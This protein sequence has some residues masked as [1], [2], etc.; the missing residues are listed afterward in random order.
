[1]PAL[2][3]SEFVY[4]SPMSSKKVWYDKFRESYTL[5]TRYILTY[6]YWKGRPSRET[7]RTFEKETLARFI[8]E[9]NNIEKEGL[10]LGE[11]RELITL[12]LDSD[13]SLGKRILG[14]QGLQ[15]EQ[16][17]LIHQTLREI[18]S[19]EMLLSIVRPHSTKGGEEGL[20]TDFSL[21]AKYKNKTK[22]IRTVVGQYAAAMA[23]DNFA[24]KKWNE[25]GAF[26][27]IA[28]FKAIQEDDLKNYS[29]FSSLGGGQ[30]ANIKEQIK[31]G[32]FSILANVNLKKY[33]LLTEKR[34]KDLHKLMAEGLVD[35][36][37]AG[38]YRNKSIMTDLETHYPS[39]E[40]VPRAMR[41]FVNQFRV[42]ENKNPNPIFLASWAST[43]FVKIHPFSDFNGRMSRLIMNMVLRSY[44]FP[45]WVSLKSNSKDRHKYFTALRQYY[46]RPRSIVTLIAQQVVENFREL[47][48]VAGLSGQKPLPVIKAPE[49]ENLSED[50]LNYMNWNDLNLRL[51]VNTGVNN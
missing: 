43:Q 48:R 39:P 7:L 2:W 15:L 12:E 18:L 35:A 22:E 49:F 36:G 13:L 14:Q 19:A 50:E 29:Y 1:M 21:L 6:T 8:F 41:K 24:Y 9:S 28:F 44:E 20:V 45:F 16:V 31:Q 25:R 51:L 32:E 26:E 5:A 27:A 42:L 47:D 38:E 11:T 4:N 10:S 17:Q 37:L 40:D 46:R 3:T 33:S 23:A 30:L 34:I